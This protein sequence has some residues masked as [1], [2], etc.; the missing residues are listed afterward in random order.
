MRKK[1]QYTATTGFGNLCR[2]ELM[3][4]VRSSANK[5]TELRTAALLRAC[6][7]TGWRRKYKL[8]GQPDFVWPRI[9]LLLFVDG[10]FWHGHQCGR[11]LTPK[12]NAEFWREKIEKTRTRDTAI[13]QKLRRQGWSVLSIWECGLSKDPAACGERIRATLARRSRERRRC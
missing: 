9:R 13:R 6:G 11:N 12:S 3:S 2:S 8:L 1:G 7:L 10:C 5:T 4:R